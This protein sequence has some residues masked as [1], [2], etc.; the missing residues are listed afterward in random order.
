M[1]EVYRARYT[2]GGK[3]QISTAGGTE[4]QWRRDGKELLYMAG[5]QMMAVDVKSDAPAFEAGIPKV[6]FEARMVPTSLRNRYV[7]TGDAQRFLVITPLEEA[8]S[9]PLTVVLKWRATLKR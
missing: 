1:G 8:S 9:T 4:P 6:L 3:W 2:R 5:M 7:A